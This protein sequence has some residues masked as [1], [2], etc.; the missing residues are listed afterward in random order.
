M[1]DPTGGFGHDA[2][3]RRR[4]L[5]ILL[6]MAVVGSAY[7]AERLD[8][9]PGHGLPGSGVQPEV[10]YRIAVGGALLLHVF[11]VDENH[12]RIVDYRGV[13]REITLPPA[14][15]YRPRLNPLAVRP[16]PPP[17]RFSYPSF[18]TLYDGLSLLLTDA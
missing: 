2:G 4:T 6:L 10:G 7:A 14:P 8:L 17:P 11:P 3:M 16:V 15:P 9:V 18:A 12:A 5:F 13:S 1:L